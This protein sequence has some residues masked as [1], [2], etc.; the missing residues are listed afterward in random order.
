MAPAG[1][2]NVPPLLRKSRRRHREVKTVDRNAVLHKI[3]KLPEHS[4]GAHPAFECMECFGVHPVGHQRRTNAVARDVAHDEVKKFAALR[5]DNTE[6]ATDGVRGAEVGFN[7]EV[8]PNEAPWRERLLDASSERKFGFHFILTCRQL[9]VGFPKLLFDAF[10]RTNVGQDKYYVL[11]SVGPLNHS[12]AEDRGNFLPVLSRQVELVT[13]VSVAVARLVLLHKVRNTFGWEDRVG[14]A[15][16]YLVALVLSQAE[17]RLVGEYY[18]ELI[19]N[20]GHSLIASRM[21]S[22]WRSQSGA[23][24]LVLGMALFLRIRRSSNRGGRQIAHLLLSNQGMCVAVEQ[25]SDESKQNTY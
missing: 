17:K 13:I 22:V 10:L 3:V 8:L 16:L 14:R 24:I 9:C 12:P 11:S 20:D 7:H 1:K 5:V 18:A 21:L 15:A 25:T 6:V 19:I 23:S 2:R 4:P